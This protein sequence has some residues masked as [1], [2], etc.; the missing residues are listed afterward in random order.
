VGEVYLADDTVLK[1]RVALK[2]LA[3]HL[4]SDPRYRRRLIHEAE[5]ASA[6]NCPHIAG[7]YDVIEQGDQVFLVMEYVEGANLR[8]RLHKPVDQ[9]EFLRIAVQCA[10]ALVAAHEKGIV[11]RDIKP[12]N[13]MLTGAGQVKILDFG[14]ARRVSILDDSR[15]TADGVSRS[16]VFGGTPG[17]MAPEMLTAGESDGRSDLF[18]L[19][20]VFHEMLTGRH[21]FRTRR[22]V[23]SADRILDEVPDQEGA[24]PVPPEMQHVLDRMLAKDPDERYN[25][26]K[27]LLSDLRLLRRA[28]SS[29][30]ASLA[31]LALPRTRFARWLPAVLLAVLILLA[32]AIT[33]RGWLPKAPPV[34]RV[35]IAV[36]PLNNQTGNSDLQ[37]FRLTMTQMLVL[38]LTGSP[39]VQVLPYERLLEITEGYEAQGKNLYHPESVQAIA[40]FSNSRFVV[41]PSV[42]AV[43]N[44]LRVSAEYRDS[45]TGETVG[46]T[47]VE[48]TISH[49]AEETL[50][51]VLDQL[52]DGIQAYFKEVG[53]GQ[54]YRPRPEESRPRNLAA[55][56]EFTEAK[57][58]EARGNFAQVLH[59][60]QRVIEADPGFA[61]AYARMGRIYALLGYDDKAKALAQ[62]AAQRIQPQTPVIDAYYIEA[63]L[64]ERDYNFAAAEE[65][66][67]ELIRIYPDDPDLYLALASVQ[68]KRGQ[69]AQAIQQYREALRLDSSFI[70]AYQQLGAL[71]GRTGD[72]DQAFSYGT[73]ALGLY[74]ALGKAEGEAATL[75]DLGNVFRVKGEYRQ[76]RAHGQSAL[77]LFQKLGN[78]FGKLRASKLLGDILHS[79]GKF[80]E[81]RSFYQGV[82]STSGEIHNN[83]LVTQT[84]M[85]LGVTYQLQGNLPKAVEFYERS[86]AQGRLY[87]EYR[88]WPMLRERGQALANLGGILIEYGPDP[89][90]GLQHL[91]EALSIFLGMGDKWWQAQ[92]RSLV[93]LHHTN[94]GRFQSS[95]ESL[96]Q[97]QAMFGSV[98]AKG[99]ATQ[100]T[101][102]LARS[103]FFQNQYQK[104]LEAA[105]Q[106]LQMSRDLQDP[107]RVTMSQILVGWIHVRLGDLARARPLLEEGAQAAQSQK[108]GE[109]L[110][111]AF[112][113]LGELHREAGEWQRAR[114]NFQKAV[115]LGASPSLS[116]SAIEARAQLGLLAAEQGELARGLADCEA[117]LAQAR[118][119]EHLH[120][121]ARALVNLASV[122]LLRKDYHRALDRVGEVT[123][124]TDRDLGLETRARAA[125]LRGRALESLGR[126]ADAS[127]SYRLAEQHL[128]QLRLA[129]GP[130]A[131]ESFLARREI[132]ALLPVQ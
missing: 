23:V 58:A 31:A 77:A 51:A 1:R 21:P 48:K 93:G 50:Y 73:Q 47:K 125:F 121:L 41:V 116:E 122:H 99:G 97:S 62:Q 109:L 86:L 75:V 54:D 39:N 126:P 113:A 118:R 128:Q 56:F 91:E 61:M 22:L 127:A 40:N 12:E 60:Y 25:S 7:I 94:A 36:L 53:A 11:H 65:K 26:A 87:G 130:A 44:T 6:L 71:Y 115:A 110:P 81:A 37:R 19:G 66:Y 38:D 69:Y 82:L 111:D 68:E 131:G 67:R 74:R 14:L 108:F 98:G 13:I 100:A 29:D 70:V 88:D 89:A 124:M 35:R 102:N 55:A 9:E 16:D 42:F 34:D 5:R 20:V 30:T 45:Q 28:T 96:L 106:A 2:R 112:D 85:N 4:R 101:Y 15:P 79:E 132:H 27:D 72:N 43:G 92:V 57:N 114:E 129:L 32:S 90:R 78:E 17:Y 18:S 33:W 76:A 117:A 10:E 59:A 80:E 105:E 119:L 8:V 46:S 104:A 95:I 83:R 107:F 84:L 120:T 3:S 123:S 64:A 52:A 49:S 24:Q 103:Y 63:S